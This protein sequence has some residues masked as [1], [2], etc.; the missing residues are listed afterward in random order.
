MAHWNIFDQACGL[1]YDCTA[2][3]LGFDPRYQ[4]TSFQCFF[5][6]ES[7]W[8]QY[9]QAGI[10]CPPCATCAA[11]LASGTAKVSV[12]QGTVSLASL[13]VATSATSATASVDGK[14]VTVASFAAG[15]VTF[16][17]KV[18]LATGATLTVTFGGTSD[19]VAVDVKGATAEDDGLR[20]RRGTTTAKTT[21]G[22]SATTD[23]PTAAGWL[24]S[25]AALLAAGGAALFFLGA[26]CGSVLQQGGGA[27]E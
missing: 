8:G 25:R 2:G 27:Q 10:D 14:P 3:H 6:A 7:G 15:V 17:S 20:R 13:G 22:K 18:S 23:A 24:G 16:A 21:T 12:L 11:G 1:R 19:T 4:P 26:L 9:S 5:V